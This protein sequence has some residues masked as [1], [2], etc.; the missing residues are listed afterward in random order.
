MQMILLYKYT[1]KKVMVHVEEIDQ[2]QL[3]MCHI[4]LMTELGSMV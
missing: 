4:L 3:L 1:N 2:W